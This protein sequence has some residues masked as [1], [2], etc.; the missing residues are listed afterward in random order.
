MCRVFSS[1]VSPQEVLLFL[2]KDRWHSCYFCL[3]PEIN[4]VY[5]LSQISFYRVSALESDLEHEEDLI[6]LFFLNVNTYFSCL[7]L[8]LDH[9]TP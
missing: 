9:S 6:L 8:R 7:C 2:M 1:K 5:V 3:A 4:Q